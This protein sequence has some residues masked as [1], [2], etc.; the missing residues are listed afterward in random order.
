MQIHN[1]VI[2]GSFSYNGADLSNVTSSNAY[3]AS[4]STRVTQI[5]N[6]YA[7]TG[8]NSFRATQS[9]TGSLTVTGQIIAQSLNVQQVTS[10][11]VYSS[12]SNVFGCDLNSRQT[13]TGSFYQTGSVAIFSNTICALRYIWSSGSTE[14]FLTTA[15]GGT[16]I[17]NG[18]TSLLG[19]YSS[20]TLRATISDTGVACFACQ[21]C[22][23]SLVVCSDSTAN[24]TFICLTKNIVPALGNY[25][26]MQFGH[27]SYGGYIGNVLTG[28]DAMYMSKV[29]NAYSSCNG[30]FITSDSYL[31]VGTNTPTGP[32]EV[33]GC[34][35][36]TL[37][38]NLKNNNNTA[39]TA[40]AYFNVTAGNAT[41]SLLA[42]AGGAGCGGLY[43]ALTN[44]S[45]FY[46]QAYQ[47]G[48]VRQYM[49]KEGVFC[50]SCQ[51]CSPQF[52][53]PNFFNATSLFNIT[54]CAGPVAILDAGNEA[55]ANGSAIAI[56]TRRGSPYDSQCVRLAFGGAADASWICAA[57]VCFVI[58][59]VAVGGGPSD[60]RIKTNVQP[61]SYG[62]N[63]IMQLQPV[64]YQF[65]SGPNGEEVDSNDYH[66][67][68]VAQC[69]KEIL[70]EFIVTKEED[71]WAGEKFN[72]FLVLDPSGVKWATVL[73]K[74]IQEQQCTIEALKSCLGIS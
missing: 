20:N 34:A 13:F 51:V 1:A 68:F 10:S 35:N 57:S 50:F 24:G 63:E 71:T 17:G 64:T 74:A 41:M 66:L 60:M 15:N 54:H 32:L 44:C 9:I 70:P 73:T 18:G 48:P 53:S 42:L 29:N 27:P 49:S 21:I 14:S 3:S 67:G 58:N 59:G 61:L 26:Q 45:D 56:R 38:F 40:R 65:K 19:L 22:T 25:A 37:N 43:M 5:E 11:I 28:P 31:G 7:T 69:V 47:S 6:V 55:A 33:I 12:G 46:F 36:S 30:L 2:T 72:N 39:G 4:L 62:L 52:T 23:P 8:S 16:A